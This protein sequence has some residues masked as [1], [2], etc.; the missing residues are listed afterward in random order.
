MSVE[1]PFLSGIGHSPLKQAIFTN[2]IPPQGSREQDSVVNREETI[3]KERAVQLLKHMHLCA[4]DNNDTHNER[5]Y[6]L[7]IKLLHEYEHVTLS[8]NIVKEIE[9]FRATKSNVSNNY[10]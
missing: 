2:N 7:W 9:Q 1:L 4:G 8:E 6:G 5:R 10:L 3:T